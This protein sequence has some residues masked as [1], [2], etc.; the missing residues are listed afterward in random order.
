M[1]NQLHSF[2]VVSQVGRLDIAVHD[3][4]E[5]EAFQ[6]N[7]QLLGEGPDLGQGHLVEAVI[8]VRRK[9]E[10]ETGQ[11][12]RI[13]DGRQQ[14]NHVR[15]ITHFLQYGQLPFHLYRREERGRKK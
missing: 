15:K 3:A 14:A 9:L 6:R 5:V 2:K 10:D 7:Q 11:A 1:T 12:L 4:E 8:V 13:V